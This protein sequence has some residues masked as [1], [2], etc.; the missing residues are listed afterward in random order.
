MST[1]RESHS[2]TDAPEDGDRLKRLASI[3]EGLGEPSTVVDGIEQAKQLLAQA[4]NAARTN[5]S[6]GSSWPQGYE[7]QSLTNNNPPAHTVPVPQ[8]RQHGPRL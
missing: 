4:E 1:V 3:A 5:M 8:R 6:M 2:I 7:N